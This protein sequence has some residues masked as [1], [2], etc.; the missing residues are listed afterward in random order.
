VDLAFVG[1]AVLQQRLELTAVRGLGALAFLVEAFENLVALPTAVLLAGTERG[2][3]TEVLRLLLRAIDYIQSA[4]PE[5]E[6]RRF[7]LDGWA[8]SGAS[9]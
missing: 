5:R 6:S 7:V 8:R 9:M 1:A 2:R 4:P 3:Q